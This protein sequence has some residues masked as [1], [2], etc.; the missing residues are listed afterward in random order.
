MNDRKIPIG[1]NDCGPDHVQRAGLGHP[2]DH[3]STNMELL[4]TFSR[5]WKR[6]LISP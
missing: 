4:T 3:Y 2:S 6:H 5:I 1:Y